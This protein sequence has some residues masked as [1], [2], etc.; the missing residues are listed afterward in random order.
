MLKTPFDDLCEIVDA[1]YADYGVF[2]RW[3]NLEPANEE[4]HRQLLLH[5]W[6]DIAYANALANAL[7]GITPV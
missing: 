1:I 6:T 2:V 4:V 5:G 3:E 7:V